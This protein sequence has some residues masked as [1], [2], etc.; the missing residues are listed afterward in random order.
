MPAS[1]AQPEVSEHIDRRVVRSRQLLMDALGNLLRKRNFDDISIQEIVDKADLTR[2]TFYLHYPDKAALLQAMTSARFGEMLK[3]RG[4]ASLECAGG[5]T[6]IAL[7]VCEYLA[8]VLDCQSSST[9][10]LERAV[11]PVLEGIFREGAIVLQLTRGADTATFAAI[12]AWAIYGAAYH[13]AQ[14]P[15]RKPAEQMAAAIGTI[16]APMMHAATPVR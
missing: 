11:I 1:F 7:G 14:T 15:D 6:P 8:K 5:I 10:P 2:A 4:I 16:V 3:K 9:M 12:V 13:W